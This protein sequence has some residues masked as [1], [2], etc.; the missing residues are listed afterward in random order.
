MPGAPRRTRHA[1]RRTHGNKSGPSHT[2]A[3][4][5]RTRRRTSHKPE[6]QRRSAN[7]ATP[8]AHRQRRRLIGSDKPLPHLIDGEAPPHQRQ[9]SDQLMP[10]ASRPGSWRAVP[11]H[12]RRPRASTPPTAP[13]PACRP[14]E[15]HKQHTTRTARC[16]CRPRPKERGCPHPPGRTR[17]SRPHGQPRKKAAACAPL[18]LMTAGAQ[19]RST[20][21]APGALKAPADNATRST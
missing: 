18:R 6:R 7:S 11:P 8:C 19:T 1:T 21:T 5:T 20:L 9:P 17:P 4:S 3:H 15:P 16:A 10:R 2:A 12:T 14:P 13:A